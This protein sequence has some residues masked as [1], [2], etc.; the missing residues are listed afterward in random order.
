M[1]SKIL[2]LMRKVLAEISGSLVLTAAVIGIFM[3]AV[4]NQGVMRVVV[5]AIVILLGM[6]GYGLTS[7][8]ADKKDRK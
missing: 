3:T 5:P 6:V 4:M 2:R 7:L 8:I 1:L